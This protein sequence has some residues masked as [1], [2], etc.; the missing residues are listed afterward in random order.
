MA[1]FGSI[2]LR[3]VWLTIKKSFEVFGLLLDILGIGF[4]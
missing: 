1:R 4:R 2:S 3:E